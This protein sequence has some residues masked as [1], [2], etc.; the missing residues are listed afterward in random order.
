MWVYETTSALCKSTFFGL[1]AEEEA[2]RAMAVLEELPVPLVTPDS[3][4]NRCAYAWTR[5]LNRAAAA[6]PGAGGRAA[7]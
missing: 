5:R 7:V 6:L 1:L 3:R 4:Q 2:E